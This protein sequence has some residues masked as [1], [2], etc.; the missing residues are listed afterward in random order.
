MKHKFDLNIEVDLMIM[1][2]FSVLSAKK[3]PV[4]PWKFHGNFP[5]TGISLTTIQQNESFKKNSNGQGKMSKKLHHVLV[6]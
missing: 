6:R 2:H 4:D 3:F 5:H 1:Y